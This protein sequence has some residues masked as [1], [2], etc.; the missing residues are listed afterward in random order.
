[1]VRRLLW[2]KHLL[3]QHQTSN[4]ITDRSPLWSIHDSRVLHPG[5][6]KLQEFVALREDDANVSPSSC[7]VLFIG[8]T[9]HARCN[10]S[11]NVDTA[12]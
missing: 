2:R 6:M 1:M 8:R 9:N 4:D 5:S 3:D 7:K 12:L 11:E 10:H